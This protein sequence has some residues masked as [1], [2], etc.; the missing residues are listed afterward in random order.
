[1]YDYMKHVKWAKLKVGVVISAAIVTVFFAVMFA[2]S[3]D[4]LFAPKTRINA[5]FGDIRGLREGAPVWFAGVEIGSVRSI[6]FTPGQ[7]IQVS[8]AVASDTMKFLKKDS[9]ASILTLGLLGDKYIELTPGS[10]EAEALRSRDIIT[11]TTNI[12]VQ[13][14]VETGQRS[15]EKIANFVN[16][17]EDIIAKIDRGEGTVSKFIKDPSVYDNLRDA[18]GDISSFMEKMQDRKST[19][20]KLVSEDSLYRDIDS[21]VQ[22]VKVFAEALKKSKGT[23]HRLIE[24]PSL[25]DRFQSA[26]VS[27]DAFSR[28]LAGSRGTVN[29]LIEDESLYEN[30]NSASEKM[31]LILQK[32]DR[33]EGLVGGLVSDGA[34]LQELKSTMSE[35]NSLIKDIKERP[36]KYFR[37]SLF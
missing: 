22:D 11:G 20:G 23:V 37:F 12:E 29:R 10:K 13:D 36:G 2:G 21:A 15:I 26:S 14:V 9:T 35:L 1:M 30:I 7:K 3:I 8:M 4:R 32:I 16:M 33:G 34:L 19:M 28:K 24:D 25:Y 6:D 31:N 27:L 17:L 5:I 18:I